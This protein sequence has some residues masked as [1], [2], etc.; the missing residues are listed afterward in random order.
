MSYEL[1]EDD[2]EPELPQLAV[3]VGSEIDIQIA[4]ARKYPRDMTRFREKAVDLVS[5][6]RELAQQCTFSVP[7]RGS[8]PSVR[9]AEVLQHCYGNCRVASR[10]VDVND[11]FVVA[12]GAFLDL[13][14]NQAVTFDVVRPLRDSDGNAFSDSLVATTCAAAGAIAIRTATLR[15][16]PKPLWNPIYQR[17]QKAARCTPDELPKA[18]DA[19]ISYFADLGVPLESVLASVGCDSVSDLD[20]GK[21]DT[22]RGY[23][24]SIRGNMADKSDIFGGTA[25]GAGKARRSTL[26]DSLTINPDDDYPDPN[27]LDAQAVAESNQ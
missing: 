11:R 16:I 27:E 2:R 9:F 15:G 19:C 14:T 13:E 24:E 23:A 12:Q 20:A 3:P 10:I 4:T 5:R 6:D 8:G 7:R 1:V 22:L 21:I 25:R 17:A 26:T 18:R